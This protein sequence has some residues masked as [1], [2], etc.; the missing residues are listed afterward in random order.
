MDLLACK[1]NDLFGCVLKTVESVKRQTALCNLHEQISVVYDN[2]HFCKKLTI[3]C[4]SSSFVPLSLTTTG[5][6]MSKSRNAR[7]IPSAIMS[8]LVK[9]PKI[10]TKTALTRGSEQMMRKDDLT[11]SEVALPPESRKFA[12][13]PPCNVSAS[14][15]LIASPAPLTIQY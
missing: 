9:P 13:W 8:H 14:T 5:T 11:V 1:T 15:V 2:F 10:L 7:M 3:F 4:P 12:Q 6:F